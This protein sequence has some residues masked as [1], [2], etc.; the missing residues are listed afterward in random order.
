M[1]K[2]LLIAPTFGI[3]KDNSVQAM[4]S[5]Y[6]TALNLSKYAHVIVL[7]AGPKPRYEKIHARLEVYRLWNIYLKDPVN[8]MLAPGLFWHTLRLIRKEKPDVFLVNKFMFSNAFIIPLLKLLGKKVY[9]Q[10]DAFP[11]IDWVSRTPWIRPIMWLYLRIIGLPLLWMSDCVILFHEGMAPIAR[12]FHINYRVIHNGVNFEELDAAVIAPEVVKNDPRKVHIGFVGRLESMKGYDVLLEV[13]RELLPSYPQTT[14]FMI[15]N[16]HGKEKIIAKYANPQIKFLGV[17]GDVPSL[18]KGIDI[19]VLPSFSEGLSNS[20]MEAM[21]AGCAVI[22]MNTHGG[23]RILIQHGVNGFLAM[24]HSPLDLKE[25][26]RYCLEHQEARTRLG[27]EARKAIQTRFDWNTI[28]QEY[29][30]L[31]NEKLVK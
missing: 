15:G 16:T 12:R 13:C 4:M 22:T 10:I 31:F 20:L 29:L 26:I 2:I 7:A 1:L 19:F 5:A 8:Y 6:K 18:L 21:A 28:V 14:L 9:T 25:K 17:R 24:L 3:A 30:T 23:N 27:S 11:S